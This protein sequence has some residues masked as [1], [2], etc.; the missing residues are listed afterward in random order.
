[1]INS[2]ICKQIKSGSTEITKIISDEVIIS[3]EQDIIDLM[4]C[5]LTSNIMLKSANFSKDFFKLPTGLLGAVLGKCSTYR[6]RLAIVGDFTSYMTKNF[7]DFLYETN[8][9]GDYLFVD[10]EEEVLNRWFK[11]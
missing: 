7:S 2:G 9:H 8:R 5:A 10:S 4:S 6:V 11:E 1:M 3:R